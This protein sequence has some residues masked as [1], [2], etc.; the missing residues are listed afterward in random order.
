MSIYADVIINAGFTRQA[1]WFKIVNCGRWHLLTGLAS[2]LL[3]RPL[4]LIHAYL[5]KQTFLEIIMYII[6]L[7]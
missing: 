7:C 1:E 3:K 5:I 6:R 2:F 4:N